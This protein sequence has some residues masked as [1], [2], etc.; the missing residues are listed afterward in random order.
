MPL[1]QILLMQ[2][3]DPGQVVLEQGRQ[4]RRKGGEPVLITL[5]GPDGQ[6][7]HLIVDIF[8]P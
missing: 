1:S 3:L 4:D 7:L 5:A 8:A 6:L 2:S